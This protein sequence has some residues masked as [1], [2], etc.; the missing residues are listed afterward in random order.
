ALWPHI[1]F[2]HHSSYDLC[3]FAGFAASGAAWLPTVKE[4]FSRG[5]KV[6][7][8]EVAVFDNRGIGQSSCPS[9]K[10]QYTTDIMAADALALMDHL[11]WRKAHVVGHSMGAMIA[12][13]LTLQAP[14]RVASLTLIST[15]GG[16]KEAIPLNVRALVA[17][18]KGA[19]ARGR[20]FDPVKRAKADLA[21]H[22]SPKLLKTRDP[23]TGRSVRDLLVEEYVAVSKVCTRGV[24]PG[25]VEVGPLT[26]ARVRGRKG[27]SLPPCRSAVYCSGYA[28][29]ELSGP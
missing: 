2:P 10:T 22:F 18:L 9:S 16:G 6:A 29:H 8:L 27:S 1:V 11:G 17:G 15:T 23:V 3:A 7:D 20:T 19:F 5:D 12:S 26:T 13:R 24:G 14:G 25:I 28:I 4:L 21:F